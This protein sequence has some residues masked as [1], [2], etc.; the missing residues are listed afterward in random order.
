MKSLKT[1]GSASGLVAALGVVIALSA[2][3]GSEDPIEVACNS[4]DHAMNTP[5][6]DEEQIEM[7]EEALQDADRAAAANEDFEETRNLIERFYQWRL[8]VDEAYAE[9]EL[10]EDMAEGAQLMDEIYRQ[11]DSVT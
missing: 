10:P 2:C 4:F 6:S 11:C 8:R 1:R 7:V 3:S 9:G 5:G